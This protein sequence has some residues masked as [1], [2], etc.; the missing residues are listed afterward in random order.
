[1]KV[2]RFTGATMAAALQQVKAALGDDAVILDT[3]ETGGRAVVTV[4]AASEEPRPAADDGALVAEVRALLAAVRALVG[5]HD[6]APA[7]EPPVQALALGLEAGGVDAAV[8]LALARET[9]ALRA[10][11]QSME[12]ALGE[13][14]AGRREPPAARVR[15]FVGAPGDGKTT[16]LVKLAARARAAGHRVALIAADTYRVGARG[17]LAAYARALDVPL[18]DVRD[19]AE[20]G[21][22]VARAGD[23]SLV[24]VDTPGAGPGQHEELG[25]LATLVEAAGPEAAVTLVASAAT[26]RQAAERSC[27]SFALLR[28]VSCALTK[29]DAVDTAPIVSVLWR[30]GLPVAYLGTGRR[31]PD[32]LEVATPARLARCLLP[33]EGGR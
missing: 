27:Q 11:D 21:G 18:E 22:A 30:Q 28:P 7:D 23:A 25:E 13:L 15:L 12:G 4:A 10:D 1:M 31:I 3:A 17:E 16:T 33:A 24:L 14:L 32:D 5:T 8:A 29:V 19:P 2:R 9:R 26:S 20:L 6:A